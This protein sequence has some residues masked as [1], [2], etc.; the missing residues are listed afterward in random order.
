MTTNTIQTALVVTM[1]TGWQWWTYDLW[2]QRGWG[3]V[4]GDIQQWKLLGYLPV[5]LRQ[6]QR[7]QR[8]DRPK[9]SAQ[10]TEHGQMRLDPRHSLSNF[11]CFMKQINYPSAVRLVLLSMNLDDKVYWTGGGIDEEQKP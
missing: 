1:V 5:S 7:V 2:K 11:S 6:G 3:D 8:L 4:L 10:Q 9:L